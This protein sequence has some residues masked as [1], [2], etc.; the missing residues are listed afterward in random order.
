MKKILSLLALIFSSLGASTPTNLSGQASF[1]AKSYIG[2]TM[3]NG[4]PYNPRAFTLACNDLPLGTLVYITYRNP[5]T[6]SVRN[7]HATVTD[8]G[9]AQYLRDEGRIFDLSYALFCHLEDPKYGIITVSA[10]VIDASSVT[11]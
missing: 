8:R 1:Y 11:K 4:Q 2:K 3:A 5:R 7:A 6:G 10:K 9:P